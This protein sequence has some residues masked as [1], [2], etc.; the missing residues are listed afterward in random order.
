MHAGT[1]ISLGACGSNRCATMAMESSMEIP[2][3]LY[4]TGRDVK[5][6]M[7][8]LMRELRKGRQPEELDFGPMMDSRDDVNARILLDGARVLPSPGPHFHAYALFAVLIGAEARGELDSAVLERC[9]VA[10]VKP[11]TG[12]RLIGRGGIAAERAY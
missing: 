1:R 10:P 9:G 11:D 12:F 8:R 4:G 5:S 6:R 7:R 2:A 3:A